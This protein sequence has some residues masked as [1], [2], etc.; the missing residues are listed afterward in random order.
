MSKT[1]QYIGKLT[2]LRRLD[3]E[4][5]EQQCEKVCKEN[6]LYE[7]PDFYYTW[8]ECLTS[9]L[10]KRYYINNNSLYVIESEQIDPEY[11]I[12]NASMNDN[13]E[14]EFEVKYYNGGCSFNEA[15]NKAMSNLKEGN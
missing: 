6:N 9:E 15:L 1:V 2:E 5:L 12:F 7:L 10:Y 4:T 14:I 8:A 13:E 3:N 11:D